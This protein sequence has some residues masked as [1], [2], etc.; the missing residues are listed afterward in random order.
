MSLYKYLSFQNLERILDGTI[1]FTQPGAFNDPFEMVPELLV[2]ENHKTQKVSIAFSLTAPRRNPSI[3]E[4]DVEYESETCN[5]VTSRGI[6]AS[7]DKEVGIVCL[8]K[9]CSSLL[10]WSHY[11]ESYAGAILEVDET[12]E[13]FEGVF[14]VEYRKHRPKVD[15]SAYLGDN[16]PVPIAELCVKSEEWKYEGESR[17]IRGLS[18]CKCISESNG[19]PIYVMDFPTDCIKAIVL[20]ERMSVDNQR[21]VWQRIKNT[22]IKLSLE[23]VSNWGYGF[24]R[25]PIKISGMSSPLISPRTAHM[26]SHLE[27]DYGEIARWMLNNHKQKELVNITL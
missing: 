7:L 20:G 27:G 13:F 21:K 15:L 1:R 8:T 11:A 23:A 4:L 3:G 22:P 6:R 26:F 10:M 16:Q 25:E 5:D 2:P 12:H 18:D 19:Y 24:R 17:I 9:N 14:D